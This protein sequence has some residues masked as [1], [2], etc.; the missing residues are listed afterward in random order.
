MEAKLQTGWLSPDGDFYPCRV[1]EHLSL[2]RKILK[3]E[4]TNRPDEKLQDSGFAE[5]TI[6]QLGVKEWRVYWKNF[7]TDQ[8][9]NFLKPYFEDEIFPMGNIVKMRWDRENEF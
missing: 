5:I 8:Q 3:D 9:K 4:Y 6:S 1:Y 2:A 7:L